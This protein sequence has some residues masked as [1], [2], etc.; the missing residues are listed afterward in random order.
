MFRDLVSYLYGGCYQSSMSLTFS[1]IMVLNIHFYQQY[2]QVF[3]DLNFHMIVEIKSHVTSKVEGIRA[4]FT[5]FF[6]QKLRFYKAQ[7]AKETQRKQS[8]RSPIWRSY[9]KTPQAREKKHLKRT[10]GNYI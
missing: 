9:K 1:M 6:F 8:T 4:K 7:L 5:C 2:D 10:P 3:N